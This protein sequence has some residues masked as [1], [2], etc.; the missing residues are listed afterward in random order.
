MILRTNTQITV[1]SLWFLWRGA[2]CPPTT[3]AMFAGMYY[4]NW[5]ALTVFNCQS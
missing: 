5:T 3:R 4:A 2:L 1:C